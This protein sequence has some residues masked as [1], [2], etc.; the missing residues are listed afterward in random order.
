M[1]RGVTH[2]PCLAAKVE[3]KPQHKKKLSSFHSDFAKNMMAKQ[4]LINFRLAFTP[5]IKAVN[6]AGRFG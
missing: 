4:G 3:I 6:C 5:H 2:L 1:L